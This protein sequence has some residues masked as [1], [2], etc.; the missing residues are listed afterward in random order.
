[1]ADYY[2]I[3]GMSE[4]ATPKPVRRPRPVRY[5]K[6]LITLVSSETYAEIEATAAARESA[7]KADVV[8]PRLELGRIL[9]AAYESTGAGIR[10]VS[11][12][13]RGKVQELARK[14][15]VEEAEAIAVLLDFAIREA[16][17]REREISRGDRLPKEITIDVM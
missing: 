12:D 9:E 2:T 15:G 1:M 13:L 7:T 10:Y 4:N 5:P 8:R 17:K 6:Q 14:A 11:G 3:A 16:D